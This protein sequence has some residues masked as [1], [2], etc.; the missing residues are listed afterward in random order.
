MGGKLSDVHPSAQQKDMIIEGSQWFEVDHGHLGHFLKDVKKNYKEW[1]PKSKT[2][3]KYLKKYY[4][5]EAMKLELLQILDKKINI[6]TT[7]K[8]KLPETK[9]IKLPQLQ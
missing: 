3:S 7:V 2:Q 4:S 1:L 8:L 5:Y 6:P 9:I